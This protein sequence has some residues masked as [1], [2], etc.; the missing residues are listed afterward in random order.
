MVE[1]V[2]TDDPQK[3]ARLGNSV[4]LTHQFVDEMETCLIAHAPAFDQDLISAERLVEV[5]VV[6]FL[7]LANKVNAGYERDCKMATMSASD[8]DGDDMKVSAKYK[9]CTVSGL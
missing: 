7:K 9:I 3:A 2:V 1:A 4:Q 5:A 6:P 8:M